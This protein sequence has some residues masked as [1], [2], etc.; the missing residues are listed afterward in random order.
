M[1]DNFVL[2]VDNPE[3]ADVD[4]NLSVRHKPAAQSVS[5]FPSSINSVDSNPEELTK[6]KEANLMLYQYAMNKI[7]KK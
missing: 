2:H 3:D 6:L 4:E 7:L 5:H 1:D